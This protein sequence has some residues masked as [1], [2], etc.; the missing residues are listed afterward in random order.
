MDPAVR[1]TF[2]LGEEAKDVRAVRVEL[3]T[4]RLVRP[5]TKI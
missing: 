5:A 1:D 4:L 2:Q 3:L